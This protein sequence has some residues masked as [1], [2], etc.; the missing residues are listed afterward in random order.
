MSNSNPT[1]IEAQINPQIVQSQCHSCSTLLTMP[2]PPIPIFNDPTCSIIAVP[3]TQGVL[4]PNCETYHNLVIHPNSAVVLALV[5][6][7][8]PTLNEDK[9]VIPFSGHLKGLNKGN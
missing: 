1:P 3:H 4:C 8:K 7:N 2:A 5:P 9:K 6:M